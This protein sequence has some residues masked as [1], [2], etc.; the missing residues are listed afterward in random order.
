METVLEP[1]TKQGLSL[2]QGAELRE[3]AALLTSLAATLKRAAARSPDKGIRYIRADETERVQLYPEL[4]AEASCILAGLRA[5]G[6]KPGDKAIF[7]F[8]LNE[9]FVPAFWACILGGFVPVP[10]SIPPGYDEPHNLLA[11]LENAWGMLDH[12]VVLAGSALA[13]GLENFARRHRLSGFRV[14]AIDPLRAFSPAGDWP[15]N[16]PED[17]ALLLLT[18][19]STGLPKAVQLN[20]RNILAR[21]AATAQGDGFDVNDVS[22]NWMPLDHV[23]G[24]VMYHIRDV[25]LACAQIQVPTE[26]ILQNPLAWLDYVDRYR[27]SI[28]WAPNFA[29][30]LVNDQ[31]GAIASGRWDLSSLRF[32]LN[33]GE[34]IVSKTARRFLALLAPH[35]LPPCAMRPAWGMSETSSGVTSSH[36]FT[37]ATTADPDPF[38]EVGPPLPG[39]SIRIVD[40]QGHPVPEGKMG[41]LQ[42]TG[43]TVTAGY[44]RNPKLNAEAFTADGWFIT[45]DLGVLKDGCLTITGREKDV[46]IINGVNFYSHELESV[47][48]EID[49]VAV[50]FTAACAIRRPGENTDQVAIFFCPTTAAEA[51]LPELVKT[52]RSTVSR[53]E[54]VSPDFIVPLAKADIP[55]TAIGKIQRAQ[56]KKQFEAGEFAAALARGQSAA[57]PADVASGW[58]YRRIWRET[59]IP[60]ERPLP[61]GPWLVLADELGLGQALAENLQAKGCACAVVVPGPAFAQPV[62]GQFIID[63]HAPGDYDRVWTTLKSRG[64]MP[65]QTVHVWSYGPESAWAGPT[66]F[67]AAQ[68]LGVHSLLC[69][70]QAVARAQQDEEP[71]HLWVISNHAFAVQ[72]GEGVACEKAAL[73]GLLKTLPQ[74]IP[75]LAC[76][77]IDLDKTD[78]SN[79]IRCLCREFCDPESSG[80]IAYRAGVRFRAWL[81]NVEAPEAA[82]DP[83]LAKGGCYVISGGMGGIGREIARFLAAEHQA[84][85]LI[86]GRSPA[87]TAETRLRELK[88][89]GGDVT[90]VSADIADFAR[91]S[92][93]ISEAETKWHRPL[94]GIFHLAGVLETR[95]LADETRETLKHSLRPKTTG[96]WVLHQIAK[97]R[98]GALV[99]NFS[100]LLGYFGGYRYGAY[101]AA[102]AFLEGLSHYQRSLGL[103]SYC[104]M[105]SGWANTG[106]NQA[107]AE[108]E[109]ATRAKGYFSLT[110]DQGIDSLRFALRAGHPQ[111]V[112]GLNGRNANIRPQLEAAPADVSSGENDHVE[113]RTDTESKLA[114]IW[115][116]LLKRPRLGVR[117]NFFEL[118][119]RSLLA[120]RIFAQIDKVFGR[121]LPLA[122]LFK[123]PTIEQLAVV[124]DHGA[125]AAPIC[126]VEPIQHNGTRPPFFCIPGGGSDVI[127]FRPL[128]T[129]LGPDQPFYGLQAQGLDG[130]K[131]DAPII[132]ITELAGHFIQAMKEIQPAGPYCIGGHCFGALLAYEMAQQLHAQGESVALLALLDPT[133][134]TSLDLGIFNS[135]GA[136]IRYF[137]KL[138]RRMSL[139]EK[140]KFP[141]RFINYFFRH[142]VVASQRLEHTIKRLR[143]LH[144]GYTLRP[145]PGRADLF[146]ATDSRHEFDGDADPRLILGRLAQGGAEIHWV[147]GNHHT[148][149]KEPQ[150]RGLAEKMAQ[151]LPSEFAPQTTGLFSNR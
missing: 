29:F 13:P 118:G 101:A 121:S 34:A 149:L 62:L 138:Y 68:E 67:E 22:M 95:P 20:H 109:A 25:Y 21:S 1:V 74:E 58:F 79:Q 40:R 77:Q 36:R 51:R 18:S 105:W 145:Y 55:K 76:T 44:Y 103:R 63:P 57:K 54:S 86:I 9:D 122:T 96:A 72:A 136:K 66:E 115:Q 42:V 120:A 56:L 100:S 65:R 116:D 23:G 150:A 78:A 134:T 28:T 137:L 147:E 143:I 84:R 64:Q 50:S 30:G 85:L 111:L 89:L 90:Y 4:V 2:S 132:P 94:D 133:A 130:T 69:L 41:S 141:F 53:K 91:V 110:L 99:V 87:E 75:G 6:M 123:A 71:H 8:H 131:T 129:L 135:L 38:V 52:I 43:P 11:K 80:E 139:W 33:G 93:V 10:I 102:N 125:A 104:L 5:G 81:A 126:H 128:S 26:I 124:I 31:A 46:I 39:V 98:P 49:G 88:N 45:G 97:N 19:G 47:V 82:G 127:V 14:Q 151:R 37:L 83:S 114:K 7:Q 92:A 117:D 27:V 146:M 140:V 48:E 16:Q 60:A 61:E 32:V 59:E 12:P 15:A 113:P 108:A 144:E 24:L 106:M 112:I 119:G 142:K 73:S 17:L 148:M 107:G 3:D 70:A 35:G